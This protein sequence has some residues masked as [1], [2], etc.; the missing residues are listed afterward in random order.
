MALVWV[1]LI[2]QVCSDKISFFKK[3]LHFI[4][5]SHIIS[6]SVP[7]KR[8]E[9]ARQLAIHREVVAHLG[10][11][12][13]RPLG[14]VCNRATWALECSPEEVYSAIDELMNVGVVSVRPIVAMI[15]LDASVGTVSINEGGDKLFNGLIKASTAG[16]SSSCARTMLL[17]LDKCG[18]CDKRTLFERVSFLNGYNR[19]R[20]NFALAVLTVS[21]KIVRKSTFRGVVLQASRLSQGKI[22]RDERLNSSLNISAG[23]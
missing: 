6:S 20:M 1:S 8:R 4:N 9:M 22:R 15:G 5:I 16:S 12:N 10:R 2:S 14:E 13:N 21:G 19:L 23:E 7:T 11:N 3:V 18:Q 17:V